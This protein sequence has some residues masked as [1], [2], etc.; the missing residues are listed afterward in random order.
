[1]RQTDISSII[2]QM[3]VCSGSSTRIVCGG[4]LLQRNE[5]GSASLCTSF[6]CAGGKGPGSGQWQ[7]T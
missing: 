7:R 5:L 4:M 2:E 1:M 6:I 3:D